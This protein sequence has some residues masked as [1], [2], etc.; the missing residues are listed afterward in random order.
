[1][2]STFVA[3]A[4]ASFGDTLERLG[5]DEGED[6]SPEDLG[7]RAAILVGAGRAWDRHLGPMLSAGELA[8]LL[9]IGT[10]QAVHDRARRGGLLAL[11]RGSRQVRFPAFQLVARRGSLTHAVLPELGAILEVVEA[12]G[13][14]PWT[15]A[16][17]F[18]TPSELLDAMTPARWL[19]EGRHPDSALEAA[20]RSAARLGQ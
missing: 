4:R 19:A 16:S 13:V 12:A 3:R 9:G 17:W 10:R 15:V 5:V 18:C 1:M 6:A 2:P 20:R 14:D 7:H 11:H 8:D